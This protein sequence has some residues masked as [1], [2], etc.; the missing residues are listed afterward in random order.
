[1]KF[2]YISFSFKLFILL[3][4]LFSTLSILSEV[5]NEV[6]ELTEKGFQKRYDE[7]KNR[8]VFRVQGNINSNDK[9]ILIEAFSK[10]KINPYLSV[11][12]K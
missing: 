4:Q 12:K 7:I 6:I 3:I 8:A 11:T 10:D 5:N 1:M 2:F 9:F